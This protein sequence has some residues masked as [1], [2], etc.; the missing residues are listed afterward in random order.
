MQNTSR[1]SYY[2]AGKDLNAYGYTNDFTLVTG[3]QFMHSF[4]NL[5]FMP[6]EM[7]GGV[8]YNYDAL[9]DDAPGYYRYIDQKVHIGSA[10]FQNEW[11]NDR[12][13]FLIGARLD[14]HN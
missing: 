14:K 13:G 10:Y 11:K 5:L 2:G 6:A 8:E 12:W 9:A 3:V 1:D 7:T 4:D